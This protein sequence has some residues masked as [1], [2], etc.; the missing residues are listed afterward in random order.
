LREILSNACAVTDLLLQDMPEGNLGRGRRFTKSTWAPDDFWHVVHVRFIDRTARLQ[1]R[2]A[3]AAA[4]S[5]D[6]AAAGADAG[7]T[8][9]EGGGAAATGAGGA[10]GTEEALDTGGADAQR[11]VATR[12]FTPRVYGVRFSRGQ[13]TTGRVHCIRNVL[14]REWLPLAPAAGA[15]V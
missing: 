5:Q 3:A 12:T 8:E 1:A 14:R 13:P 6:A 2:E 9:A 10:A 7:G 11:G 4:Q 15:A